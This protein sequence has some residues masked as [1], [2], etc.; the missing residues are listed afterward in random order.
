MVR[1]AVLCHFDDTMERPKLI[2]LHFA[3]DGSFVASNR[4]VFGANAL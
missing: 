3:R 1:D 2:W 4:P